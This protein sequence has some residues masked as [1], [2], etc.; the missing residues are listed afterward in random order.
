MSTPRPAIPA[1]ALPPP[2]QQPADILA[3]AVA[4]AHSLGQPEADEYIT[5]PLRLG[6]PHGDHIGLGLIAPGHMLTWTCE[7]MSAFERRADQPGP[8]G[9]LHAISQALQS[10]ALQQQFPDLTK[11]PRPNENFLFDLHWP[12]STA[13]AYDLL[14]PDLQLGAI[15][16]LHRTRWRRTRAI[17]KSL[18]AMATAALRLIPKLDREAL[19]RAL[20]S[21][22]PPAITAV[23]REAAFQLEYE[24]EPG[25]A[26][27]RS[28][29]IGYL[30]D[31]C[32]LLGH[33]EWVY[34]ATSTSV[35]G[36]GASTDHDRR[37]SAWQI[38]DDDPP[39]MDEAPDRF[40]ERHWA[41][42]EEQVQLELAPGAGVQAVAAESARLSGLH[43]YAEALAVMREYAHP[44]TWDC[45]HPNDLARLI[46]LIYQSPRSARSVH[47]PDLPSE[48]LGLRTAMLSLLLTGRSAR[49]LTQVRKGRWPDPTT[50]TPEFAPTYVPEHDAIVYW[51][52]A[53]A[54]LPTHPE[55]AADLYESVS[56]VWILPL[57]H[58]LAPWWREAAHRLAE[59]EPIL[60]VSEAQVQRAL[61]DATAIVHAG[62]SHRP[63][64][65]ERRLRNAFH[66]LMEHEADF[67]PLLAAYISGQWRPA[68]RVPA[69]YTTVHMDGLAHQYRAAVHHLWEYWRQLDPQLP[70]LPEVELSESPSAR[71]GSPYLPRLDILRSAVQALQ[72]AVNQAQTPEETHNARTS[73]ALYG[74]SVLCAFRVSEA[75]SCQNV[76]VDLDAEW[77]GM[78][79]PWVI[80]P[81][82][83][84]SRWTTAARIVPLPD[85]LVPLIRSVISDH[86]SE[87]A[88]HYLADGHP[89]PATQDEIRRQLAVCG[90]PFPR[91]HAGRHWVRTTALEHGV[92]FDQIGACLGHQSAG[93]EM[94]SPFVPSEPARAWQAFRELSCRLARL[95]DWPEVSA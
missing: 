52:E 44:A 73:L 43:L 2:S 61:S 83:K 51:P 13:S 77:N 59:G 71:M 92:A 10:E 36:Q 54:D 64:I 88:F 58:V 49:W 47:I 57:P 31:C 1:V 80:L 11:Q 14:A 63:A 26:L 8:P 76:D 42:V 86:A 74:L 67:D 95:L 70:N 30:R 23:F 5:L 65:T 35:L 15:A 46:R 53:I 75:G 9:L 69:F 22:D 48:R 45:A 87:Y 40:R 68:L 41:R 50:A 16:T 82:C 85:L 91:W 94:F 21:S 27:P 18:D 39:E 89:I 29:Q 72:M 12:L 38:D 90:V 6:S 17:N 19:Q 7:V 66:A 60:G 4:V 84:G 3:L 62:A 56:P 24:R 25:K 32:R 79:M 34:A 20:T 93:R 37:R 55:R 78:P 81:E 33:P 28:T